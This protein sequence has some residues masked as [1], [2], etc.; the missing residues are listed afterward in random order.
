MNP[1]VSLISFIPLL[2]KKK[3]YQEEAL[4]WSELRSPQSE[5]KSQEKIGGSAWRERSTGAGFCQYNSLG[6]SQRLNN[7]VAASAGFNGQL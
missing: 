6:Y 2:K 5:Q 3:K 4:F 1:I 7:E